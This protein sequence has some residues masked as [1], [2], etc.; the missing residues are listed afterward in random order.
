MTIRRIIVA[1]LVALAPLLA[2][3]QSKVKT[4]IRK[5]VAGANTRASYVPPRPTFA[6]LRLMMPEDSAR[7]IVKNIAKRTTGHLLD[8]ISILESD[9]VQIFGQPAYLQLQFCRNKLKTMVIN[10]HPLAG[11]RYFNTRDQVTRHMTQLLGPGV[12]L[13]DNSLTYRRWTTEDGQMEIS[14]SDKYY[15]VFIRLGKNPLA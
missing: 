9:S 3:A 4:T 6:G 5:P 8:S 12:V 11:D 1:G 10:Y 13:Q 7:M 15:R 2:Y 14:H